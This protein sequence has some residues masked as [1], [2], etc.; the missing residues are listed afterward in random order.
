[1]IACIALL[2]AGSA[3]EGWL[4]GT[5]GKGWRLARRYS[6]LGA[7]C[8]AATLVNPYGYHLHVHVLAYLRSDW[9][10]KVVQEFQSPSFRTEN[11]RQFEILMVLGVA[12]AAWLLGRKQ[13][14]D[15]VWILFWLHASLVSARHVPVFAIAAAP[16]VASELSA[17]WEKWTGGRSR[18]SVLGIF[19]GLARDLRE[20][21][22]RT[23]LW[24]PAA[25]VVLALINQPMN[26]PRDFPDVKFPVKAAGH[27]ADVLTGSKLLTSD[28]WADYLIF[29]FYPRIRVFFDGRSDFYGPSVGE[30][31]LNV[32]QGRWDWEQILDSNGFDA[33]LSPIDWPLA[34]L[35]KQSP[36]WRLVDDDGRAV[37][38]VRRNPAPF[39]A[40]KN[41]GAAL[42]K[43][44]PAAERHRGDHQS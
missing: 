14:T 6:S 33:V 15:A 1:M 32:S 4:A 22:C 44:H 39:A 29:R 30:Q 41:A 31:Y 36:G 18:K 3:V 40:E 20:S 21:F 23:S 42:M 16:L 8:A 17:G 5:A 38:F 19:D 35:L 12:A 10:R 25:L 26:W 37:L 28:Q 24:A 34:S 2:A 13:I 9:I 7:A 43:S 11:M 27:H